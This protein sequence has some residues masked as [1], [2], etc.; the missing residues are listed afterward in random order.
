MRG[1]TCQTDMDR[2]KELQS[3]SKTFHLGA[4]TFCTITHRSL[5]IGLSNVKINT[6]R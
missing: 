1:V 6:V 4:V 2:L 3:K 5:E